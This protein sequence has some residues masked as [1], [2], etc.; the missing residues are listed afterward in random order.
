[1]IN[2]FPQTFPVNQPQGLT[3][4]VKSYL[5]WEYQDDPSCQA[6]VDAFNDLADDMVSWFNNINL[7]IYTQL[8]GLLL[9]WVSNGLYGYYRPTLT[10]GQSRAIGAYGTDTFGQLPGYGQQ[11]ITATGQYELVNDDIFKRMITWHRYRGDGQQYSTSWLKRRVH[12][13][14]NGPNGVSPYIDQTYDVSVAYSGNI[15]TITIP[16]NATSQIFQYAMQNGVLAVP[17]GYTYVVNL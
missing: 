14:L 15:I 12:R 2:G 9:D 5:Y 7:P 10:Q 3:S 1:M 16:N 6:F 4:T 13:F 8:S 11:Q 17:V